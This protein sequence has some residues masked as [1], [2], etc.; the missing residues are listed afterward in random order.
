MTSAKTQ[1]PPKWPF[2]PEDCEAM[3]AANIIAQGEQADVLSG[4]RRFNVDEYMAIAEAGILRKE[5][6]VE[7][8]DG[9]IIVMAPIG[10]PHEEG[11]D[12]LTLTLLPPLIGRAMVRVQGSMQLDDLSL[13]EPDVIVYRL[14]PRG[15][16]RL[17]AAEVYFV[18][19]V[20][21][22]SLRYDSGPKLARYAEAG[23]PEVWIANLR[24]QEVSVHANP[25]GSGY[26]EVRVYRPGDSITLS[27]FPDVSLAVADFMPPVSD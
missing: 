25:S 8:M 14:R 16:G 26:T 3:V 24:A 1:M 17:T 4:A 21:D 15:S 18:I 6:R 10:P 13:P 22:S 23:V 7:L 27:A 9:E 20:A 2:S 11:T 12:W 19:E 5:D